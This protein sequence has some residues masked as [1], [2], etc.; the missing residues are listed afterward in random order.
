MKT[1][2]AV[3]VP[4]VKVDGRP[5]VVRTYDR[6]IILIIVIVA[7]WFLFRPVFAFSVYYRGL[8]F[9]RMF[10]LPTALHYYIKSTKVYKRVPLGWQGWA[11]LLMMKA[12]SDENVRQQAL[13]VLNQGIESNPDYGP[14][15]FDLGRTHF[16]GK[17]FP[18]AANAFA[19]SAQLMP[20]D[21]FSWDWAAW[22]AFHA[23][24]ISRA[25]QY[26]QQALRIDPVFKP[27]RRQLQRIANQAH[28]TRKT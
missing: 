24:Q 1:D 26:W 22:S 23:G 12:P 19:R 28:P 16:I 25:A 13:S 3:K 14:L 2:A 5:Y 8:S 6:W 17:E 7:G 21:L 10:Q 20:N 11:E 9:E 27:A 18:Q 15:W 4:G